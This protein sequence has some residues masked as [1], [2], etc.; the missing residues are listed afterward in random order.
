MMEGET[1]GNATHVVKMDNI[2][3]HDCPDGQF[4]GV[5]CFRSEVLA[6]FRCSNNDHWTNDGTDLFG[7]GIFQCYS[8]GMFA[9][10]GRHTACMFLWNNMLYGNDWLN[11]ELSKSE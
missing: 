4:Y 7:S 6:C 1:P 3:L 5:I 11:I 10:G 8:C 9:S 2:V